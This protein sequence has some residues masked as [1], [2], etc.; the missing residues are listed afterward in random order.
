[1][2][3]HMRKPPTSKYIAV[4]I[5]DTSKQRFVIAR[6]F[7]PELIT[8]LK[9]HQVDPDDDLVPADEV[10]KDLDQKYGKIGSTIR[11]YR[12]RD[13]MTQKALTKK[14]GVTQ[15]HLSEMEHSKRPIGKKMAQKFAK[16]F[17]TDYRMFL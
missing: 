3:A 14:L 12:S 6:M 5:H 7:T 11:G 8:F 9:S 1:M 10:F 13:N 16:I 2:S 15:G 4:S 17:N